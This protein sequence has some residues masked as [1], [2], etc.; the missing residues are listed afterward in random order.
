MKERF[1]HTILIELSAD[2]K[3]QLDSI[4]KDLNRKQAPY[5]KSDHLRNVFRDNGLKGV[6]A[7]LGSTEPANSGSSLPLLKISRT[8]L[9]GR[10][11][12]LGLQA[13]LDDP[14]IL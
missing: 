12:V 7:F 11:M 8:T 2:T 14:E 10:L 9:A 6:G 4:V 13:Y 1:A 5:S 3:Q